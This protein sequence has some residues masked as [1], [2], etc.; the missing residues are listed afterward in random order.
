MSSRPLVDP[1]L[2]PFLEAFPTLNIT[3]ETLPK[4]REM[5]GVMLALLHR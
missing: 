1:E 2:L 5:R 4:I 3:A